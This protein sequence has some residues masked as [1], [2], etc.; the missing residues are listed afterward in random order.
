MLRVDQNLA[1]IGIGAIFGDAAHVVEEFL[2][3]VGTEVGLGDLLIGQVRH[4]RAQI[5]DAIVDA[6][7]GAGGEAAIAA[8]FVLRR[9][10]QHQHRHALLGGRQRRAKRRIAGADDNHIRGR[11]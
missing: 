3:G 2:L 1:Q 6:A 11:G 5:L 10:L 9:A 4:Q 7:E 8:G